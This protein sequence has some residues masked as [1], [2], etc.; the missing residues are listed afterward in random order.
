MNKFDKVE[1]ATVREHELYDVAM[2]RYLD[3][4]DWDF[5]DWL[6]D[7]ELQEYYKCQEII[8]GNDACPQCGTE[9]NS[10]KCEECG[11]EYQTLLPEHQ[12]KK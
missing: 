5:E 8:N 4:I 6:T 2:S 11:Y 10:L 7:A 1:E 3:K 12:Q 9:R